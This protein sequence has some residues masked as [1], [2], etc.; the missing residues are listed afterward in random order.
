MSEFVHSVTLDKSIC[1]GCTR[2]VKRCPTEAIRVHDGVAHI[3][4][5]RCIDCGECIRQC[6]HHAKKANY[7]SPELLKNYDLTI[8][9]P[10]PALYGQ[11]N[12]LEDTDLV[13]NALKAYGFDRVFEV[14]AAAELVSD[15]TRHLMRAATEE[16]KPFI[17]SACPAVVRLIRVRFPNLIDRVLPLIAPAELAARLAR[18]KAV[19]ET[20][21]APERIGVFFISPCPAKVTAVKM[22]IGSAHSEIDG[23]LAIKEL[24]PKLCSLMKTAGDEPLSHAG[25]IGVSWASSG[26]E[27]SGLVSVDNYLAAD[28]IENVIRVLEDLED[29]KLHD[30]AFVELNACAGGCVGGVLTVENPYIARAKLAK[31]RRYMP[32]SEN[33]LPGSIPP[34]MLWDT[35]LEYLPVLELGSTRRERFERYAQLEEIRAMLPD[36][37]CGAC[38]APTCAALAEDIVRGYN[39]LENCAFLMRKRMQEQM[40]NLQTVGFTP[41]LD[42]PTIRP[43]QPKEETP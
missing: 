21:I 36:L 40:D 32:V 24:Y 42:A 16:M 3:L 39:K 33:H 22:P 15:A 1:H 31:L 7:D 27:S 5:E 2:C 34:K 30:L 43:D 4:T 14:S 37:D 23:V 28:G 12:N 9:L 17:S 26:G 35:D 10:A 19:E 13:L 11:F 38:G 29:E 18:E 20:G 8:A 41:G 25:R 6:P